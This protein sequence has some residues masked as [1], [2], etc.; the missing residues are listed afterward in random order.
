MQS[1][2]QI[3][4]VVLCG[5]SGTR[6][7]P[8]SRSG[9]P[10]QFLCLSGNESLFQQSIARLAGLRKDGIFIRR[11]CVVCNEEHRFLAQEQ[12]RE[13]GQEDATF[14]LEPVGRNTAPALTIL[15][16][17]PDKPET[18]YGYIKVQPDVS[19]AQSYL[20]EGGYYWNAGL[21]VLKALVWLNALKTFRSDIVQA[22]DS[23]RVG[24]CCDG[25]FIRRYP[26]F[27]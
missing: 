9:F 4:P 19:T 24:K 3:Q 17:T 16:V 20:D 2:I 1:S 22:V 27:I 14:L 26:I 18:S 25:S 6:L 21:F 5:G 8:L 11:P 15:G 23:T 10:K 12:L 13:M 7:W